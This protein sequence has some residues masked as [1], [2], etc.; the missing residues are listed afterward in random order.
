MTALLEYLDLTGA[1]AKVLSDGAPFPS[2][3]GILALFKRYVTY[4]NFIFGH[5][6]VLL[7]P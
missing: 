3:P 7:R 4:I 6:I 1:K 5:C 2:N